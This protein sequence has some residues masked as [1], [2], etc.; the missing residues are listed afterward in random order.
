MVTAQTSA[1]HLLQLIRNGQANTRAELQELTG[2]SRSTVSQRLEMLLGRGWVRESGAD[3]ST[4]GRPRTRLEFDRHHAVVLAAVLDTTHAQAAVLDLAGRPLA[5]RSGSLLIADGPAPALATITDWFQELLGRIGRSGQEVCGI[6]LAVPGPV[7]T[8]QGRV[9]LPPNMPGWDGYPIAD[10]LQETLEVPVLVDNDANVMALGEHRAKYPDSPAFVLAKV[11]TGIG[12]GIVI[13]GAL[14]RGIDGG[15][16]DLG[17]IRMPDLGYALCQCG[18][19]GCL[20]AVASGRALARRLTELGV[21]TE[22]GA[23]FRR[24]L[25][26]GQPDAA[27]LAREAGQRVGEVLTTVVCLLNPGLLV[28][29]G[30]LAETQFVTGVREVLYQRALPRATRNLQV[31]TAELGEPAALYGTALLVV[32]HLYS[33]DQSNTRLIAGALP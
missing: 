21:P 31:T 23:D 24:H 16:G 8:S 27:R 7:D 20:A 33:I 4:G 22:S 2:L 32:D 12:A 5:E 25:D 6:G 28:I 14:Y 11:S 1:G 18:S 15:A 10:H 3:S 30:D 29:A 19:R 17:H 26:A 9:V 13:D